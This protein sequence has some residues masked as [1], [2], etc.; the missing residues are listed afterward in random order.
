MQQDASARKNTTEGFLIPLDFASALYPRAPAY[1]PWTCTLWAVRRG[2]LAPTT[3][4]A[5]AERQ[6]AAG[7]PESAELIALCWLP[8]ARRCDM[9]AAAT[10]L[11]AAEPAVGEADIERLW[12][13]IA[14]HWLAHAW[15]QFDNAPT[16]LESV[17]ADFG[18]PADFG[19]LNVAVA[20]AA[21][22]RTHLSADAFRISAAGF[23]RAL[24]EALGAVDGA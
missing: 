16:T 15:D 11:A 20:G 14:L 13:R 4:V 21:G 3:L 12:A 9:E 2:W 10:Q 22:L 18:Y 6:L 8:A 7:A 23:K 24:D 1:S 19:S 17:L 5:L